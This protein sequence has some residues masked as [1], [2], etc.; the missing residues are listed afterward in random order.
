MKKAV[1]RSLVFAVLFLCMSTI[2]IPASSVVETPLTGKYRGINVYFMNQDPDPAD[3]G[4]D[5]ELRWRVVV[6]K[7]GK[8]DNL[9]FYLDADYPFLFEAGDGPLKSLGTVVATGT[10]EHYYVLY[11][12]LRVADNALKGDYNVSLKW[13]D[14]E[15]GW[16]RKYFTLRVDPER[17]DFVIGAVRTSPERLVEDTDEALLKVEVSNIGEGDAENVKARLTL[18]PGFNASYAYSDE[19][20]LGTIKEDE[21]KTAHFYIDTIEG[22]EAGEYNANLTLTYKEE[23]DEENEYRT[24]ILPFRIPIKRS[25]YLV[26]DS[27]ETIP[28]VV[29][30]DTDVS[31]LIR[32]KN[33]GSEEADAVSLRVFKDSTQ[34]FEYD[35]KSDFVGKLK[36]GE[37]GEA[38]IRL[39]VK[40]DA[41]AKKYLIDVELRGVE[42]NTD[43]VVIFS[44]TAPLRVH[45]KEK[46]V[47]VLPI[48]AVVVALGGAAGAWHLRRRMK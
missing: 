5:V 6:A 23:D 24:K 7:V 47:P 3:A 22:L 17:P 20:T 33:T 45:P 13:P 35:E 2:V 44:R 11:Y 41:A 36:P 39:K 8:I 40:E 27:V 16:T 15:G 30:P 18:P 25:P 42:T 29:H 28:P 37:T 26:I 32:V 21:S 38:L 12:R 9:E 48:G 4:K 46:V 34:P 10:V 43:R 1:N 19:D 14:G 31:L